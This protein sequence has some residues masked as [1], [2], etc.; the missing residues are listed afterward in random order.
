MQQY[1]LAAGSGQSPDAAPELKEIVMG[2]HWDPPPEE[3][4]CAP[5]LDAVCLLLDSEHRALEVIHPGHPRNADGSVVHTGDSRTGSSE[6]DDE[7]IFVFLPA[8]PETFSGVAFVVHS[9]SQRPFSEVNGASCHI[10]DHATEYKWV[11]VELTELRGQTSHFVALLKRGAAGWEI[12]MD[13][14][15]I[16]GDRYEALMALATAHKSRPA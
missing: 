7:R 14:H 1:S 11:N 12:C 5:D 10:S 9:A 4:A 2:L 15:A 16:P 8:L 6:W 13:E 3:T